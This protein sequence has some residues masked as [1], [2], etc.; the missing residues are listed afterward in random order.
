MPL[1]EKRYAH[2]LIDI[3]VKD[4]MLDVYGQELNM[5]KDTYN[6]SPEFEIFLLNPEVKL[7]D[8]K[9]IL[10]STLQDKIQKNVLSFILLL[11]DKNRI[12]HLPGIAEEYSIIADNT[13]N[14]LNM[15]IISAVPLEEQQ[16]ESI[17]KKYQQLYKATAVEALIT[18][19]KSIV[20]GIKVK[21]GDKVIDGSIE[22]RL[23]S[24]RELLLR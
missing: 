16:I 24:L 15:T 12:K 17:K 22:G 1:V 11:L 7:E 3:A 13:R 20:G 21:I 8:K 18:V 19:D 14:T 9:R 2:A 6:S 10:S 4:G 5:L 23:E